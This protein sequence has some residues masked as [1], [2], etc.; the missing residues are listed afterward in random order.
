MSCVWWSISFNDLLLTIER[1][2]WCNTTMSFVQA[3]HV[4][5]YAKAIQ[6]NAMKTDYA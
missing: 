3:K 6:E 5:N 4:E 1:Q 2:F